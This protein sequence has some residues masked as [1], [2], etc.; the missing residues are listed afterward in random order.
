M[1][2]CVISTVD[3]ISDSVKCVENEEEL[4]LKTNEKK[5]LNFKL[6]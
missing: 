2:F 4:N 3:F 5:N 6:R 1:H